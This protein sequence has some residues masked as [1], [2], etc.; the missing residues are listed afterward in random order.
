MRSVSTLSSLRIFSGQEEIDP[1]RPVAEWATKMEEGGGHV[2]TVEPPPPLPPVDTARGMLDDI[3]LQHLTALKEAL[4]PK[5]ISKEV[6]TPCPGGRVLS[7]LSR[8]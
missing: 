2:V 7:S 3:T 5:F 4:G 1:S 8:A 6:N